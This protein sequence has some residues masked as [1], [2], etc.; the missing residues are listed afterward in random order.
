MFFTDGGD[1]RGGR[2]DRWQFVLVSEQRYQI[3]ISNYSPW[4]GGG[5]YTFGPLQFGETGHRFNFFDLR[6]YV[7]PPPSGKYSLQVLYHDRHSIADDTYC[8]QPDR[9]EIGAHPGHC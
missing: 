9:L 6:K 3:L 5:V 2:R 8:S 7:A 4:N 1:D